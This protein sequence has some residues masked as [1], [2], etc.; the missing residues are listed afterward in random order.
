MTP[1]PPLPIQQ[2]EAWV[3]GFT[4]DKQKLRFVHNA[5]RFTLFH[6]GNS[7]Y[8][9][10]KFKVSGRQ[11]ATSL[12]TIDW[13]V[14]KKR[15]VLRFDEVQ[16]G[17]WNPAAPAAVAPMKAFAR[18]GAVL[19]LYDEG[20][21]L[22]N[23][24]ISERSARNNAL[25]LKRILEICRPDADFRELSSEL[26][27]EALLTDFAGKY[28][29]P[30]GDNPR[31]RES[32]KRGGASVLRQARA[33]FSV[34]AMKLYGSLR[35]PDLKEFRKAR[36]FDAKRALVIGTPAETIT[37]IAEAAVALRK[38]DPALYL[39]HLCYRH[40]GMRNVEIAAARWS[41]LVRREVA[42]EGKAESGKLK[43]KKGTHKPKQ[44]R[45][46]GWMVIDQTEDFD[47]KGALG[48]VPVP[49][50]VMLEFERFRPKVGTEYIVPAA[51]ATDR[52]DTV[53]YRHSEWLKPFLDESSSK[54]SYRLRKWAGDTIRMKYNDDASKA[55]LRHA[56][57]SVAGK[58]YWS[59][60]NW[61]MLAKMRGECSTMI[62]ITLRDCGLKE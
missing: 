27:N 10:V 50:D 41:W 34:A 47:P 21:G 56:D 6:R 4:A 2:P 38:S 40:L 24:G 16:A 46:A 20:I 3:P 18:I 17:R 39:A 55:F 48:R 23:T 62:G 58:H 19:D 14:A 37:K 15:A 7:P 11:V 26:L 33:V 53:Y 13:R 8:W 61:E 25:A 1:P 43:A 45:L 57:G 5:H 36:L 49:M 60:Y 42:P 9:Y 31:A 32:R 44:A 54:T 22:V 30:A 51:T 59:G 52:H 12:E 35:L 29:A 28:L